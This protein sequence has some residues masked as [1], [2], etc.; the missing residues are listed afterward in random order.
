MERL[1]ASRWH[2][3][4]AEEAALL[5]SADVQRGLD[6]FEL[7]A[8]RE[9]FGPNALTERKGT[10]AWIRFLQQFNQALVY[11]LI[12]A[13]II[14][15]A[16]HEYV[17][18]GVILGVVLINAIVGFIQESK[19][20]SAIH[21]LSRSLSSEATVIRSGRKQRI[22]ATDLVPGDVVLLQSGDRVPADLRLAQARDLQID[23]SALTGESVPVFKDPAALPADTPLA[24]RRNMVYSST[25][26]TY[27]AGTG[28]VTA[29]GDYTEIG[30]ISELVS[31]AESLDTP[32]TLR[33]RQFSHVLLVVI[34]IM[35]GMAF[36]V[37][38]WQGHPVR[39]NFMAAVALA[40][41]AIPEGLPAAMT[42]ILAIGVSR[43]ARRRA[44]IRRL[45]AVE[46]LGS[47]TVIC[48]DKTGTL[49]QNA[50]T[51]QRVWAGGRDWEVSGLGYAPE[52]DIR[53]AGEHGDDAGSHA[54][55]EECLRCGGLC[56]DA[57]L[58]E[59]DGRWKIE[60]DPTDGALIVSAA[61]GGMTAEALAKAFPRLDAIAFESQHQYMATLH[62]TGQGRPRLTL[63]KGSMEAV[64]SRCDG[65]RAADGSRVALDAA[66]VTARAEALAADGLRVLAFASK[67]MP[68]DCVRIGHDDVRGGLTLLG[69][70][71]MV[72]PPRAE[73]AR[74]VANC[75]SAGIE[76]KMITGDHAVTAAS[77]ARQLGIGVAAREQTASPKALTS[78]DIDALS[79]EELM[80]AAAE[81]SVF[82]RVTPENKIRLVKALQ[83][84]GHIAAMTGDGVNDAP[85]LRQANIGIAMGLSGTE[86]AREAA[87]MVLTDD[88]FA[89][90]EAAVE[91]G[92]G[93]FDNLLKFIAW[94]LPTNGGEGLVILLAVLLGTHLPVLPI[95]ILWINMTTAV[96]LGMM[97]AFEPK[98]R[99]LMDR[100]PRRPD[101]PILG[102]FLVRRIVLVS[103]LLCAAA[104]GLFELE[105]SLN[106]SEV[107]AQTVAA[108]V[109]V[110]GEL[111]YLLNSRSL[112][113]SV[114][115]VGL[116]SNPYI[117]LGIT[118][119]T[120]LQIV[121]TH[122]P[123][124]NTAFQTAPISLVMWAHIVIAGFAISLVVGTEKWISQRMKLDDIA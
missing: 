75:K 109:F 86:V 19:A 88:N 64:L 105:M 74:A 7:Q 23:E 123:F 15:L 5:L 78:R 113:R 72:D 38:V 48:S 87:D 93:V 71:A 36:A 119:M 25:L 70:Q 3:I 89:T 8:R 60:G 94:T 73:A 108:G 51:V 49:T 21:A 18:A 11:I 62:E 57:T 65:M 20:L 100:P 67:E 121:F 122:A 30:R 28:L 92:R 12:G 106:A 91:E 39:D 84:R 24:D 58:V 63:V 43:M 61:K 66:A 96:C 76:V 6:Q 116:F 17:D 124:M 90:I 29:T 80:T 35:A 115:S 42:I 22:A 55:L 16:L 1:V 95:H 103:L 77:I 110:F 13:G 83:S 107:Q 85:A 27:G 79:D 97:L 53:P 9:R 111:F 2:R 81:V 56:N 41:G 50:M 45:P 120:L 33:I 40:V 46:T 82:A 37:G 34:L 31:S 47:T 4:P 101:A 118:V 54:A 10:P 69:L 114:W 26:V 104:F 68:A 14:T 32:L 44:I 98:E 52:G 102:P 59:K 99:G 117:W 112:T